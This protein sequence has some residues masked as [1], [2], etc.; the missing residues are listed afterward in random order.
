M[1]CV[2]LDSIGIAGFGHDFGALEGRRSE[3]EELFDSFGS[4]PPKG[5][6][7]VFM[8]LGPILPFLLNI[9]TSR[10]KLIKKLHQSMEDI[11]K[12][13]LDRSR[14]EKEIGELGLSSRSIMGTLCKG[15]SPIPITFS[16][17]HTY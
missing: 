14:K 5:I 10:S 1:N 2:S 9:P 16:L 12:V 3:V 4:A 7:L 17:S 13:L 11:S 15:L 6:S 8:L